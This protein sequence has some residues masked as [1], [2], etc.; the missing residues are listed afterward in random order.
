LKFAFV[1]RGLSILCVV[2][3]CAASDRSQSSMQQSFTGEIID[4][5]CAQYKGHQHMMQ[6]MKSMGTDKQTCI[7]KCLQLGGKYALYNSD[8]G[9]VYLITNP[10]KALEFGGQEVQVTGTLNKKKLTITEIK[11]LEQGAAPGR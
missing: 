7:Q 4:T 10:D 8:S 6:E 3:I 11:P 5:I 2:G 9:T 1:I